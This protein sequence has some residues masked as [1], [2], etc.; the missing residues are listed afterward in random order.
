MNEQVRSGLRQLA[1]RLEGAPA[2]RERLAAHGLAAG[3]LVSLSHGMDTRG[4]LREALASF[5]GLTR[6]DLSADASAWLAPGEGEL[7]GMFPAWSSGSSGQGPLAVPRFDADVAHRHAR[8]WE[9][10][11]SR[12][13]DTGALSH[14]AFLCAL[15]GRPEGRAYLDVERSIPVDRVSL[16]REGWEDRLRACAPS[17]WNLSPVGLE[18]ALEAH[19]VQPLPVPRAV[20]STALALEEALRVRGEAALGCPVLDLFSTAET[21]PFAAGCPLGGGAFHVLEGGFVVDADAG[22]LRVTRLGDSPLPLLNYRVADRATSVAGTC[23]RCG[24]G[25][26][27]LVGLRGRTLSEKGEH[28]TAAAR[29]RA[30]G[31]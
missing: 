31:A 18:R 15:H 30:P 13:V 23:P 10:A 12:G 29:P 2:W 3:D 20:F 9:A 5:P 27:T 24:H 14:G 28:S 21:G 26:T 1:Q 8:T 7:A 25:G 4:A 11:R 16:C 19:A 6:A 22:G 17:F